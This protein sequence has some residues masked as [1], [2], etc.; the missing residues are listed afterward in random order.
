MK[1]G[2][3]KSIEAVELSRTNQFGFNPVLKES[4]GTGYIWPQL[5]WDFDAKSPQLAKD[6]LSARTRAKFY[7]ARVIT[8]RPFVK[9][10]LAY[11]WRLQHSTYGEI[12]PVESVDPG[13]LS[14][15]ELPAL[16][17]FDKD[18]NLPLEQKI[19]TPVGRAY[20]GYFQLGIKALIHSTEAFHGLDHPRLIVTNIFGTLHA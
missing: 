2:R 9:A 13:A 18:P 5:V 12:P 15:V 8:Y 16:E 11:S 1:N 3:F 17:K 19:Q 4:G 14:G 20:W 6:I 7:G 10:I